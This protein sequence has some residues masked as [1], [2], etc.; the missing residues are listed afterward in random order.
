MSIITISREFG[1]GGREV[2]NRLADAFGYAYCDREI[3]SEI[4]KKHQMDEG[5]VAQALEGGMFRS[6]PV[7]FG[8]TFSYTSMIMPNTTNLFVEQNK[9]LKEVAEKGNC[10]IV[11][12]A[13]STILQD[14][15]PFRLFVYADMPSKIRRCQQRMAQGETMAEREMERKIKR[16]DGERA[17][18]YELFSD[19][20]WGD[21]AGYDLCVNT[22]G[23]SIKTLVPAIEQYIRANKGIEG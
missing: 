14:Y 8:R 21:K 4:A 9:I 23:I 5:Y 13:A 11:G 12:R 19:L 10:V 2:G 3:V 22:T 20:S 15:E 1:S 18:Y 7:H 6:L 17:R 16:I